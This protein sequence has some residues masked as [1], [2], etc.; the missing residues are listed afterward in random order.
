MCQQKV[1]LRGLCNG[2]RVQ[3]LFPALA[4]AGRRASFK[5]GRPN[6]VIVDNEVGK[7]AADFYVNLKN[8]SP[9]DLL[10]SNSYDRPDGLANGDVAMY[11]A[12]AWF[13]G[14]L[15]SDSPDA[16]GKWAAAPLPQ[17][18][19][20]ATT[21][22]SDDLVV[23]SGSKHPEAAYK[24]IEFVSAPDHMRE[25]NLGTPEPFHTAATASIPAR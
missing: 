4:L 22:A 3:L 19:Q 2:L 9:A 12:G 5:S 24:W 14:T 8:Y 17:D 16:T 7:K 10:H 18:K 13:A 6:D 21:V 23:F 11:M 1:W 15:L 25:L 20:C